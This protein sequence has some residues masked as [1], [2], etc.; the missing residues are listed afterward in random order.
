VHNLEGRGVLKKGG[1]ADIVLMDLPN[2]KVMGDEIET[3]RHPKGI[4]YV[5]VNGESVVEEGRHTGARSGKVLK[6]AA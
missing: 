1:Y 6:R 2:L 4:D 3:R 5:F